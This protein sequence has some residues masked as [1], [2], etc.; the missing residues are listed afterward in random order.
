MLTIDVD[1]KKMLQTIAH[2]GDRSLNDTIQLLLNN[3]LNFS[4]E[5]ISLLL[6]QCVAQCP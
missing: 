2:Q 3:Y 5:K 1:L 4:P 6:F